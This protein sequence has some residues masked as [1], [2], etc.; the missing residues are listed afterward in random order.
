MRESGAAVRLY[1]GVV[2]HN[3]ERRIAF[4]VRSLLL[5]RLPPGACWERI[6]VVVSGSV[7]GTEAVVRGIAAADP[8]VELVVQEHREGK[9]AAIAE[10]LRRARGDW[11]V[12][13]NGDA[14]AEPEAVARMLEVAQRI[15]VRPLAVMG[16]PVPPAGNGGFAPAVRLLWSIHDRFHRER[17]AHGDASHLSDELML[18]A[19]G[20]LPPI[21]PGI[22]NDGAFTGAWIRR[23][24]GAL[25]YVPEARV[26]IA[27]PTGARD[28]VRQRRRI[29]YGHA[30]VRDLVGVSPTTLEGF[31][32]RHPVGAVG[33]VVD[34]ARRS[35]RPISALLHLIATE[36]VALAFVTLDRRSPGID[37]ARWTRIGS[38]SE[39]PRRRPGRDPASEPSAD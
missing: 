11:L 5:Q 25:A 13:L 2:A 15:P 33:L 6:C 21:V 22:I 4:A 30:Q 16:R 34:E 9:S 37:H 36:L 1:G 7:D 18:L 29:L 17:F 3:E 14:R 10:V 26:A 35:P 38:P 32:R 20:H 31:A 23:R 12:L 39:P 19:V 27:V 28:H 24:H 8:R